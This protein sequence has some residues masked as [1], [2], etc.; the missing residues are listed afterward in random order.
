LVSLESSSELA[1]LE[2]ARYKAQMAGSLTVAQTKVE[3]TTRTYN[4]RRDMHAEKLLSAQDKDEA[5]GDM[6]SAEADL[7][8]AQE[9]HQ[10]ALL[11]LKEQEALFERRTIRSNLDGVV[12]D[13]IL[14][15]GE[16]VDPADPKQPILKVAQLNP[17]RVHLILPRSAFGQI[18]LG[19]SAVITPEAP[20][21]GRLTGMV[22][23]LDTVIDAASGTF[24]AFLDVPNPKLETPSG[25]RCQVN[26]GNANLMSE[27]NSH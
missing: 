2:L 24:S 14:R 16:V 19:M 12:A 11:E 13:Q 1:A 22:K 23:V 18:K 3:Y 15:E 20:T 9:N 4:R 7:K 21:G 5:E 8:L 10:V 25:M 26:F 27:L 17:L 6:K